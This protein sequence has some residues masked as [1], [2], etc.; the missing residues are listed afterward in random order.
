MR[1][2]VLISLSTPL[3][4]WRPVVGHTK[5]RCSMAASVGESRVGRISSANP[6]A[7]SLK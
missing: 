5:M 4:I 6:K 7:A 2:S 3:S 1:N